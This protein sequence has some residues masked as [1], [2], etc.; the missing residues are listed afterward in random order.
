MN[1]TDMFVKCTLSALAGAILAIS[2]GLTFIT[3]SGDTDA[4]PV[5]Q[6][7]AEAVEC[8]NNWDKHVETDADAIVISCSRGAYIVYLHGDGSFSHA[9][10][11]DSGED[12]IFD[13]HAVP[14][15][16]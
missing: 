13:P 10:H 6:P 11:K 15:W 4:T 3:S 2:A 8:P 14:Q 5:A 7:A 9:W 16:P 12:F 1:A